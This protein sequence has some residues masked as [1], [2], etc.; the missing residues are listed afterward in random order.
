MALADKLTTKARSRLEAQV[1]ADEQV[2]H[3]ATV[4]PVALVLTDRRLMLA[5][6]VQ[7]AGPEL[8][9]PLSQIQDVAYQKG[10]LGSQGR[11][12]IRTSSQVLEYK[13]PNKQGEPAAIK[14][15]QA[16]AH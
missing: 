5:P 3:S 11:L 1:N 14:I 12:T 10:I 6:Y 15:R 7:T 9:L 16:I 4:G 13:T 2:L 8:N